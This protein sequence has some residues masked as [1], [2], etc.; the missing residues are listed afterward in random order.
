M[1][2]IKDLTVR[3]TSPISHD[4][5]KPEHSIL[6]TIFCPLYTPIIIHLVTRDFTWKC[7]IRR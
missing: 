3:L 6:F 5:K 7:D 4:T 2:E 1:D